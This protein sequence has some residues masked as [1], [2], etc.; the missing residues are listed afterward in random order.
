[1][2]SFVK[3]KSIK[4]LRFSP[5]IFIKLKPAC[6]KNFKSYENKYRAAENACLARKLRA[7]FLAYIKSRET[8]KEGKNADNETRN[9]S[10]D[11]IM[12]GDRESD[13]KSVDRGGDSLNDK[14]PKT[15]LGI[16]AIA[17][18]ALNALDEHFAAYEGEKTERDPRNKLF[19]SLKIFGKL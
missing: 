12:L 16:I 15:Y 3:R 6:D 14:S 19:K 1:M 2:L 9:E 7:E 11:E 17:F 4:N 5:E 18:A 10:F 8:N 13:G